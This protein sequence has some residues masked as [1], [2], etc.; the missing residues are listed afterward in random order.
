MFDE[1]FITAYFEDDDLSWR[2]I[3]DDYTNYVSNCSYI[4][5]KGSLTGK[6]LKNGLEIYQ[7]NKKYFYQKYSDKYFVKLFK[8]K[9]EE[10]DFLKS[11]I[12]RYKKKRFLYSIKKFIK[13]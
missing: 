13:I 3:F 8:E 7:Q 11:K 5:H 4:Y 9:E 10:T 2:F 1:S 12:L 6:T